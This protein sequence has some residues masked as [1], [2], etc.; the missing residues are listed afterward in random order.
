MASS[1][2]TATADA[3]QV[4][5][6]PIRVLRG[7]LVS[8][9][10]LIAEAREAQTVA[11]NDNEVG[12]ALIIRALADAL[13]AQPAPLVADSR[14]ALIDV[15]KATSRHFGSALS[16]FVDSFNGDEAGDVD[17][18]EALDGNNGWAM[19][20]G[21]DVESVFAKAID[22]LLA[23]GIVSLAADRDR[24]ED[25][26]RRAEDCQYRHWTSGSVPTHKRGST[27]PNPYRESE[28]K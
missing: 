23:S 26:Y 12:Y 4:P 14:E 28:G 11:F 10:E 18:V 7:F 27:Y 20:G 8:N 25:P 13:E 24:A 16:R 19:R 6:I 22:A 15:E 3:I 21:N 2:T 17:Y 5:L 9:E 1:V